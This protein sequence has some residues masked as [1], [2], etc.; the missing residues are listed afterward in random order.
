MDLILALLTVV[1]AIYLFAILMNSTSIRDPKKSGLVNISTIDSAKLNELPYVTILVKNYSRSTYGRSTSK[2]TEKLKV[3]S[4]V[5]LN[6]THR[7]R[8]KI[9]GFNNVN[10]AK[11]M[12]LEVSEKYSKEVVKYNPQVSDKTKKRR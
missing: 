6:K 7:S 10:E 5:L 1:G 12:L 9:G 4:V 8:I 11:K 2:I 3:Y